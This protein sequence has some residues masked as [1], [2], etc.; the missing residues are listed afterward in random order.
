MLASTAACASAPPPPPVVISYETKAAWIIRLEDQRL[1]KNPEAVVPP[2]PT[3]PAKGKNAIPP[4]PP[5]TPDLLKLVTDPEARV[6]RRAA[7]AIGRVGLPAGVAPLVAALSDSD[8][9]VRQMAAFGLGLLGDKT[10]AAPLTQALTADA[11]PIVKGRAAEALGMIGETAAAPAIG[12][13][14]A[15]QVGAAAAIAPDDLS[16]PLAPEVEAFRLG[17]YALTRLKAYDPLAAAVLDASGQPRVRWWPVAYAL[18]RIGDKRGVPALLTFLRS[19]GNG[20]FGASFAARGLGALKEASAVDTLVQ[21]TLQKDLNPRVHLQV[22]R[23]LGAIADPRGVTPL[24]TLLDTPTLD[25]TLRLETVTAIGQLGPNAVQATDRL[26]DFTGDR[27]PTLRAAALRALAGVNPDQFVAVLSGL[28][29]DGDFVVRSAMAATLAAVDRPGVQDTLLGMLKDS[30]LRVIPAVLRALVRTKAPNVDKLLMERVTHDDPAIRE[31]AVSL[32]GD[33]K[34]SAATAQPA[35]LAAWDIAQ[36]DQNNGVRT[37]ILTALSNLNPDAARDLL[38]RALT[39]RDWAV[40]MRAATLLKKVEPGFDA[41]T[42]M[43]PAPTQLDRAAYEALAAPKFSPHAYI[44]TKKGIIEIELAVLDAPIT[45]HNFMTLARKGFF[46]GLR[47]HRVVPDF[48]VQDGDPRG[49][50]EGG[51]GYSI[52][53]E[54]NDLPYLRGTVGMA[55]GGKDTGGSQYFLTISPAPHLDAGY[56]AFGK[57]VKG[58]EVLD[59]LQ[60]WDTIDRIRIWDGVTQQ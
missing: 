14:V 31:T 5:A 52:R 33:M 25:P 4:P 3:I 38:K 10:A 57:V 27:W 1:L 9:D 13:L 26:L 40:R 6:R 34:E 7:L 47:I 20:A 29:P 24:V 54:L 30:D 11:S 41:D 36:K 21:M 28:D 44:E 58:L 55:L 51:P 59:T 17:V 12:Q 19:S 45:T 43:R 2:A 39:D 23:A 53:D 22:V 16:H 48:V 32:L 46:N 56:T 37:A 49:D 18:Q 15:A 35:L 42:P 8:A 60:Q 50:G